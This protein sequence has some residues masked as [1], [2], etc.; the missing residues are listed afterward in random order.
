MMQICEI[1][2]TIP[3]LLTLLTFNNSVF[4]YGQ[5]GVYFPLRSVPFEQYKD[6][7][8][9]RQYQIIQEYNQDIFC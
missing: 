9:N 3:N 2:T 7:D 1:K 8:K 6:A 4:T 5:I